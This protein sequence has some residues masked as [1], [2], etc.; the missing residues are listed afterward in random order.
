[1]T[2][3][4]DDAS[5]IATTGTGEYPIAAHQGV[6]LVYPPTSVHETAES[7]ALPASTP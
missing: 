4:V 2:M 5:V 3:L 7:T 1:M 6:G